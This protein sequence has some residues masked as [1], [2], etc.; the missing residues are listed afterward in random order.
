MKLLYKSFSKRN[1]PWLYQYSCDVYEHVQL[2][3]DQAA[4]GLSWMWNSN[5]ELNQEIFDS[6]FLVYS[7]LDSRFQWTWKYYHLFCSI[8]HLI[9]MLLP[10]L[11]IWNKFETKFLIRSESLYFDR[12]RIYINAI[13][14][15]WWLLLT[16][17][18]HPVA[19]ARKHINNNFIRN[20]KFWET[21]FFR[22]VSTGKHT[23]DMFQLYFSVAIFSHRTF[24]MKRFL[25]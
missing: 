25:G 13:N 12:I 24:I 9:S 1:S 15:G 10:R 17:L 19:N 22:N 2:I 14:L 23:L 8:E 21:N 16:Q 7:P 11:W 5:K 4:G 18:E 6:P 3:V 20:W